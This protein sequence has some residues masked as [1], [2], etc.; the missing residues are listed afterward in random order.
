MDFNEIRKLVKLVEGSGIHSLEIEEGDFSI[1]I[2]GV[3]VGTY[4]PAAPVAMPQ[5]QAAPLPAA[6]PAA[7]ADAA[8]PAEAAPAAA[9]NLIEIKAPMVGTF[10]AAPNPDSAPFVAVGDTITKGQT[11]CILEAM[12]IMNEIEAEQGGRIV[13]ILVENG[14]PVQFEQ[15]LF[16]VEAL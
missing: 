5:L 7:P 13:E 11:L 6:A 8:A 1:R 15:V 10:Y 3:G 16:R 2:E 4:I 9:S 12:K 14:Q